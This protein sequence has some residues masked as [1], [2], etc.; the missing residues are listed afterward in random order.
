[1]IETEIKLALKLSI[2]FLEFNGDALIVLTLSFNN[3]SLL[4][5][6]L[7]YFNNKSSDNSVKLFYSD[8]V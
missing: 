2:Y 5:R 6:L 4:I 1:V 7:R 3:K 8:N